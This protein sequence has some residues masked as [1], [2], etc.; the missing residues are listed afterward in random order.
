MVL[1]SEKFEMKF[2]TCITQT[3]PAKVALQ[4]DAFLYSRIRVDTITFRIPI[5]IV[6]SVKISTTLPRSV[7]GVSCSTERPLMI[8]LRT[9]FSSFKISYVFLL[10]S[11]LGVAVIP[12]NGTSK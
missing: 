8:P 11:S 1:P 9:M 3:L 6:M 7:N 4:T 12:T 5:Q 2:Q 10:I